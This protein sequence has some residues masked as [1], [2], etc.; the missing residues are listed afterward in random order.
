MKYYCTRCEKNFESD[1]ERCPSCI[2]KSTV[3]PADSPRD[4]AGAGAGGDDAGSAG[5]QRSLFRGPG[6]LVTIAIIAPVMVLNMM[7]WHFPWYFTFVV[8]TAGFGIGH[9]VNAL[10][11]KPRREGE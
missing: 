7:S 1:E 8:A 3:L 11:A 5:V 6:I 2:R 9:A 4:G 10:F